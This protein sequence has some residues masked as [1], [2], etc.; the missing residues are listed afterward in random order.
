LHELLPRTTRFAALIDI[1]NIYTDS[2]ITEL[3]AA[4]SAIGRQIEIL[5]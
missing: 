2:E 5:T 4:A 1:N 3:R